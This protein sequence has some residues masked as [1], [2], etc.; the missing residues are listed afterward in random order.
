MIF[1]IQE[2][3]EDEE[4]EYLDSDRTEDHKLQKSPKPPALM[5]SKSV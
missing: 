3:T 2:G 5:K 1:N 4:A